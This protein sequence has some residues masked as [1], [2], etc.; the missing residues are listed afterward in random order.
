MRALAVELA[1]TNAGGKDPLLWI[2]DSLAS[3]ER[4]VAEDFRSR[5]QS[6]TDL[7]RLRA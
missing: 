2:L 3:L 7:V 4:A 5:V 1:L 6:I